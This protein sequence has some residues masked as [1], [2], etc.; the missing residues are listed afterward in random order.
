MKCIAIDMD[1][2]LLSSSQEVADEEK[3]AIQYARRQG[4]EIVICTGRS[5]EEALLPLQKAGLEL[6]MICVNGAQTWRED[7]TLLDSD[8]LE[9][10]QF[11]RIQ[12]VLKDIGIYFELYTNE[13]NYTTDYDKAISVLV[14]IFMGNQGSQANY[15]HLTRVAQK[16]VSDGRLHLVEDYDTL[17]RKESVELLKILCFSF[18]KGSLNEARERL[19]A[20]EDIA[21]SSSGKE[22]LEITNVE[23]QKGLA[24]ER[25][26]HKNGWTLEETMA[27]GDNYND[28]SMFKMAGTAVAM[29]NAEDEIKNH[30]NEI[31]KT[32]EAHGVAHAILKTLQVR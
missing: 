29:G 17:I 9:K 12:E 16:H 23:A 6:P 25:F 15:E 32:N 1:G 13:G 31:T 7:G 4:V 19:Q 20:Y 21:V 24:L 11:T 18:H 5:K 3:D 8:L 10:E 14:N 30:A 28:L 2:T 27:I 22:N 26:V